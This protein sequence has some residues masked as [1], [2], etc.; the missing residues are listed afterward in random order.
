MEGNSN[1]K[2]KQMNVVTTDELVL[3]LDQIRSGTTAPHC[4]CVL[5]PGAP[6]R[7]N[8]TQRITGEYSSLLLLCSMPISYAQVVI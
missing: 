5:K 7:S 6:D 4:A 8:I 1:L 2:R 3:K